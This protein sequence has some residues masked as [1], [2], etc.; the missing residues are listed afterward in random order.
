M[1]PQTGDST[2]IAASCPGGSDGRQ[3]TTAPG[4][5]R[6]PFRARAVFAGDETT[7]AWG[8]FLRAALARDADLGPQRRLRSREAGRL[9][10]AAVFGSRFFADVVIAVDRLPGAGDAG[11]T[12]RTVAADTGLADSVVRP[13]MRRLCDGGLVA[14]AARGSGARSPLHY[15]VR[16]TPLWEGV[17]SACTALA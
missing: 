12:V 1:L 5:A 6:V 11:V 17:L 3:R 9:R 14:E 2:G 16:R 7:G 8:D 15:Q 13:V 10:S 4:P